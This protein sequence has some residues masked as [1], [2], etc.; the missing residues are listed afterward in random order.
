[1][2]KFRFMVAAG[3]PWYQLQ[4]CTAVGRRVQGSSGGGQLWRER[5]AGS[6]EALRDRPRVWRRA[7]GRGGKR[8]AVKVRASQRTF[9]PDG[10]GPLLE[11]F[12]GCHLTPSA[13]CMGMRMGLGK[14]M[15]SA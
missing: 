7:S 3:V 6:T 9:L 14:C 10:R 11:F 12:S 5:Q 4:V 1:M 8:F 13:I 2:L 15:M